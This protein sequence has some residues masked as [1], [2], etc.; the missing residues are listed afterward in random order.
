MKL[1][2]DLA[3]CAEVMRAHL[4]DRPVD[5]AKKPARGPLQPGDLIIWVPVFEPR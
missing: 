4:E 2:P 1:D 3:Y 5:L